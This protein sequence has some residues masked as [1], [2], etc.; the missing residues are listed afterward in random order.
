MELRKTL[1][2]GSITGLPILAVQSGRRIKFHPRGQFVRSARR[3]KAKPQRRALVRGKKNLLI[4]IKRPGNISRCLL[5]YLPAAVVFRRCTCK[6]KTKNELYLTPLAIDGFR[7][8]P[9]T[10]RFATIIVPFRW[11]PFANYGCSPLWAERMF[12]RFDRDI[13]A[14]NGS[15]HRPR[16]AILTSLVSRKLTWKVL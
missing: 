5:T 10:F 16:N 4:I 8:L 7:V 3:E 2:R 12:R 14:E 11:R 6:K 1:G 13:F 9:G 15:V